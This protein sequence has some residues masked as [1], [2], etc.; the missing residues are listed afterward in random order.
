MVPATKFLDENGQ[1]TR[2]DLVPWTSGGDQ[3]LVPSCVPTFKQVANK[4][5]IRSSDRWL[6]KS[7]GEE[8]DENCL[9]FS[10]HVHFSLYDFG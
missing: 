6:G 7:D 1:F 8:I 5:R 4:S 9:I 2:R 3:G 10:H